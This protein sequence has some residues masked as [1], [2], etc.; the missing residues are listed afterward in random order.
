ML[1]A[2][3]VRTESFGGEKWSFQELERSREINVRFRRKR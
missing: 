3:A 1:C 2:A